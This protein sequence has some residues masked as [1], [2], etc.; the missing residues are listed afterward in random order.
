METPVIRF[1]EAVHI[2]VV[3]DNLLNQKLAGI[4]LKNIGCKPIYVENGE[5]AVQ[6]LKQ[7]EHIDL[8]L[9]DIRMPVMDGYEAT[10]IIRK[11]YKNDI[12]IIGLS[13]NAFEEDIERAL[14]SGMNAH[15]AKPYTELEIYYIIKKW[16]KKK[17]AA[18][19]AGIINLEYIKE[20]SRENSTSARDMVS[21][22]LNQIND[23]IKKMEEYVKEENW[24]ELSFNT[25]N[26]RSSV[27]I[28]GATA[29]QNKLIELEKA[30]NAQKADIPSLF[31]MVKEMASEIT[32]S[33]EQELLKLQ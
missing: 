11:V 1:E 14:E 5:E 27:R 19:A 4:V 7:N 15:I 32:Q 12:P 24:K 17:D 6:A 2:L 26:L 29:L 25:H 31:A 30:S 9:M 23:F 3:E 16:L 10:R 20:I 33:L 18:A 22:A 13:A 21:G 28:I 8:V